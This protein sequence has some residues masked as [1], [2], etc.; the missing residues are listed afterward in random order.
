MIVALGVMLTAAVA[1]AQAAPSERVAVIV[2]PA[3]APVFRSPRAAHG[4]LVVGE[5]ATVSRRGAFASLLR[6]EMGN[7]IVGGGVPGGKPLI[8]LSRAPAQVTF[9]VALPPPGSTTTCAAT[10]S[11]SPGPVTAAC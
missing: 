1:P 2:A 6:G 10:R 11:R 9:Y 3:S 7:A 4:L 8:R 5:G